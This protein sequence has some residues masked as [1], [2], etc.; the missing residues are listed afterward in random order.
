MSHDRGN[1]KYTVK[2]KTTN[3]MND[4]LHFIRSDHLENCGIIYCYSR[5]ECES[6]SQSLSS[7]GISC[8][9]YHA[10]LSDRVRNMNQD[11]WMIGHVKVILQ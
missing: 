2:L 5:K 6:I 1:L 4:I 10:G 9:P 11:Q 3:F 7:N 8:V